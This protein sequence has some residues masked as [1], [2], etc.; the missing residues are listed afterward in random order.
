MYILIVNNVLV[1]SQRTSLLSAALLIDVG[2]SLS[3]II[4][5]IGFLVQGEV[6]GAWGWFC[7]FLVCW[8]CHILGGDRNWCLHQHLRCF[9]LVLVQ[10]GLIFTDVDIVLSAAFVSFRFLSALII[11]VFF[12]FVFFIS[13]VVL[14]IVAFITAYILLPISGNIR[15][16]NNSCESYITVFIIILPFGIIVAI[17]LSNTTTIIIIIVGIIVITIRFRSVLRK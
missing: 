3:A 4:F 12:T 13:I 8:H 1:K 11:F 14:I 17:C 7:D 15:F 10:V 6:I 2:G 16:N 5:M 9:A